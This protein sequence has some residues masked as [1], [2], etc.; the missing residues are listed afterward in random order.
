MVIQNELVRSWIKE[1]K[2][3]LSGAEKAGKE[4]V[5]LNTNFLR[6]QLNYFEAQLGAT[7]TT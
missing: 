6:A 4:I 1:Y 7:K 3:L 2:T 5:E